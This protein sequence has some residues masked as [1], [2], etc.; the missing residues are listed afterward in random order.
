M[1]EETNRHHPEEWAT[2]QFAKTGPDVFIN[3][4]W[5]EDLRPRLKN[6]R[7]GLLTWP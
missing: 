2:G 4:S 6:V 1:A 7:P 3:G 5:R